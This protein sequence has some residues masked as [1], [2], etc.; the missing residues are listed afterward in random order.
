MARSCVLRFGELPAIDP[1]NGVVSKLLVHDGLGSPHLTTGI[2]TFA[3]R[4]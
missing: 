3:P 1:G 4:G 2:T